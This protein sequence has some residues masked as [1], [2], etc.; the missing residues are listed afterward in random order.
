MWWHCREKE[1]SSQAHRDPAIIPSMLERPVGRFFEGD[2]A[3][4]GSEWGEV[5]AHAARVP[6]GCGPQVVWG[7]DGCGLAV[8]LCLPIHSTS[9]Q[10]SGRGLR[11]FTA[12]GEAVVRAGVGVWWHWGV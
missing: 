11:V 1:S 3:Q 12:V 5:A 7:G 6:V 10:V 8:L 4:E 2:L 9:G